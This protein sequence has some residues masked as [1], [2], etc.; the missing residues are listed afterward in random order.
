[1]IDLFTPHIYQ[2][3]AL[4]AINK[5]KLE[6]K[7]KSIVI[8]PSGIGKTYLSAFETQNFNGKILFLVHRE[9]IIAQAKKVFQKIHNISEEDIGSFDSEIK[10]IDKKLTFAMIQTISKAKNLKKI[11]PETFDYIIVD[12]WHHVAASSYKKV[13]SHFK[14]KFLLGMTATPYRLDGKDIFEQADSNIPYKMELKEGISS[15][16]LV[17]FIY[18]GLWD[19]IDYS[20]IS[21]QGHKYKEKDLNKKLLIDKRDDLIIKE[22]KERLG[23]RKCFG[24]C[25]SIKHIKR[26][27]KKFNDAG[28]ISAGIH[29]KLKSNIRKK[30]LN[31]FKTGSI[32]VLFTRD[33]FN[34]GIDIPA[35]EG[36]L[37]LR[38]TYSKT[39]FF[40]QLG[41]GLRTKKGKD[42][43][44]VL[45]FIGNYVSAYK[46]RHWLETIVETGKGRT[47][48]KPEYMHNVSEVHFDSKVV[49]LFEMQEP[50]SKEKLIE[51][52][53]AVKKTLGRQPVYTD[54]CY[55]GH[56]SKYSMKPYETF[57]GGWT[58]FL[59]SINEPSVKEFIRTNPTAEQ[60][61]KYYFELKKELGR[62]PMQR[63]FKKINHKTAITHSDC[64]NWSE[65]RNKLNDP[66]LPIGEKEIVSEYFRIKQKIGRIPTK[67]EYD[68][69]AKVGYK[70]GKV[71]TTIGA[72]MNLIK[73]SGDYEEYKK[74]YN[75]QYE[76]S[77]Q[78]LLEI[79]KKVVKKNN[80]NIFYSQ[81][82]KITGIRQDTI[83]RLFGSW[84]NL[85]SLS[86]GR[87]AKRV[88][89]KED[90]V[91]HFFSLEDKLGRIP[92]SV[93]IQ[94]QKCSPYFQSYINQFGSW[95]EFIKII[96]KE[97]NRGEF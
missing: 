67:N 25:C 4:E 10:Q 41:R 74:L 6:G 80:G 55:T 52:Y 44:I 23:K 69:Y 37:F 93:D 62:S 38:P 97:N 76:I 21:F 83:E 31:D 32:Q 94:N 56:V 30:I 86:G 7:N 49:D 84:N 43:V 63:D 12:E 79:A 95:N 82:N 19:D 36:L 68:K 15:G 34:E 24:F 57:F 50:L 1:V 64:K 60:V 11:P 81:F 71:W 72:Y 47:N 2:N 42:N 45:D 14:P 8:L 22:V 53:Y 9:E 29:H 40:Q 65:L 92:N 39:V 18:Y 27:V 73:R 88:Y 78:E 17:P 87:V 20:D 89:T 66:I 58:P 5:S 59:K 70:R 77:K 35:V 3:K 75:K 85:L 13:L 28:I 33:I 96:K 61:S 16:L 91:K 26:C 46:I 48:F 51:N 54:F 90:L